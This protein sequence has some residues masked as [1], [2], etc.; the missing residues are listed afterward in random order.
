V[1]KTSNPRNKFGVNANNNNNLRP[2]SESDK[3]SLRNSD[4]GL[5]SVG[6]SLNANATHIIRKRLRSRRLAALAEEGQFVNASSLGIYTH[7]Y[8]HVYIHTHYVRR[9][10]RKKA[11][12]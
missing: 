3:N 5:Y 11:N 8:M 6:V 4:S 10:W 9:R 7:T 1:Q 2:G 12:M